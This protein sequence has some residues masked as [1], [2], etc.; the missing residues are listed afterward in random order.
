MKKIIIALIIL[1]VA[2]LGTYYL[3]FNNNNYQTPTTTQ[4][5][6][7]TPNAITPITTTPASTSLSVPVKIQGFAFSPS[8]LT[9]KKGTKVTWTNNDGVAHTVTSDSGSLLDSGR[10]LPGGTFSF[11][12]NTVGTFNYHCT[13][14]PMMTGNVVVQN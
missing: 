8:T 6:T 9:I 10:I 11:T 7:S 5:T 2:G 14:H 12:F 13:I 3:V 4:P 1:A